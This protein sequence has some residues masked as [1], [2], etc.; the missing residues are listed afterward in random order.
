MITY[1]PAV[2]ASE[3]LDIVEIDD[4][5]SSVVFNGQV[6]MDVFSLDGPIFL[7]DLVLNPATLS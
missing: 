6:V 2:T 7:S 1:D 5:T 4:Y 3:D